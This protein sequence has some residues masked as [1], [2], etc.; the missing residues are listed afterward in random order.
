M[1]SLTVL[2]V[3]V[4]AIAGWSQQAPPKVQATSSGVCSPNVVSN[5]GPISI[6]C[7]TAMDKATVTKIV[8]LLNR[9]LREKNTSDEVNRKLDSIL[10]FLQTNVNPNKPVTTYDC[11]GN[12]SIIGHGPNVGLS[13]SGVI[14]GPTVEAFQKMASLSNS[15]QY[16]ELLT[17]CNEQ[18]KSTPEWLTPYLFCS[19]AHGAMG[20]TDQAKEALRYYDQRTGP[21]Y[22]GD[23]RCKTMSEFLHPHLQP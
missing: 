9:I 6:T 19:F 12:S 22:E 15:H 3:V 18:I 17:V 11:G 5:Q 1:R 7:K 8:S 14:G 16:S 21:A 20:Q 13:L 4:V 10:E 23:E 2:F